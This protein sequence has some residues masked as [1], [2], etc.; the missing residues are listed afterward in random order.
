MMM[1]EHGLLGNGGNGFKRDILL[2]TFFLFIFCQKAQ[3][4]KGR[5]KKKCGRNL[6]MIYLLCVVKHGF[7]TASIAF[8]F[9]YNDLMLCFFLFLHY[10]CSLFNFNI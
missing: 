9:Y 10:L 8:Y 1:G 4:V 3:I 7:F 6:R 2:F 5:K